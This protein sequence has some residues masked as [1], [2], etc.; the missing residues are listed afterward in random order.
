M[1]RLHFSTGKSANEQLTTRR[2]LDGGLPVLYNEIESSNAKTNALQ[3]TN[4]KRINW[5]TGRSNRNQQGLR[6]RRRRFPL[7]SPL[8]LL[9]NSNY[10]R[11]QLEF[12]ATTTTIKTTKKKK[13]SKTTTT[14]QII[15]TLRIKKTKTSLSFTTVRLRYLK[16]E[17]SKRKVKPQKFLFWYSQF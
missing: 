17:E 3:S 2:D 7:I 11:S 12:Q 14:K 16:T 9:S 6:F 4:H 15:F 8:S 1:V 10:V 5:T 13:K